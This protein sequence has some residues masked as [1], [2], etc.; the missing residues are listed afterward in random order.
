MDEIL[1]F[2]GFSIGA[3]IATQTVRSFSGGIRPIVRGAVRL[4]LAATD[5][6]TSTATKATSAVAATAAEA[7]SEMQTQPSAARTPPADT[8]P[9]QIIIARE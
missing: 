7:R 5:M 4:G 6:V 2:L 3:A 8:A 9:R 1:G